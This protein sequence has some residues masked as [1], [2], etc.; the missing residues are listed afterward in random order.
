MFIRKQW[1]WALVLLAAGLAAA[2]W[3]QALRA[4]GQ[5]P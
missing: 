5:C 1:M 4:W 3:Y 2:G